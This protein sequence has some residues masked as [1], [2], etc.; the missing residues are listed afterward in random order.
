MLVSRCRTWGLARFSADNP[1][2]GAPSCRLGAGR[3]S[4]LSA[5][6]RPVWPSQ[7]RYRRRR[8]DPPAPDSSRA[9]DAQQMVEAALGRYG[10]LD[11]WWPGNY[12]APITASRTD[13]VMDA[14]AGC[15]AACR[16]PDVP[17]LCRAA[18]W[19]WCRP[20]AVEH[21]AGCAYCPSKAGTD[22][23]GYIGGRMGRSRHSRTRW[24]RRCFGPGD[25][26]MFTDD[27]KV[28]HSGSDARLDPVGC[29]R[30]PGST[31]SAP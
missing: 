27:L 30:E 24:R 8:R 5:A 28:S 11:G 14:N 26:V 10:R 12:V 2:T 4:A 20:F 19:C 21:A 31:S 16:R 7:R 15:L 1:I 3:G 22:L 18:A 9:A 6:T 23:L 17:R 13:A 29:R 25:R